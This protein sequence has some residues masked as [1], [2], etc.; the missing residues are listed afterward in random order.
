MENRYNQALLSILSDLEELDR[1]YTERF[2]ALLSPA[3]K[4]YTDSKA[5]A[6]PETDVS[7]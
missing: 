6:L 7:Q 4:Y 3:V 5:I 2:S 1:R